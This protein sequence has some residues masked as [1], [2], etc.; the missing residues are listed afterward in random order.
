MSSLWR[1]LD[2]DDEGMILDYESNPEMSEEHA[3]KYL[4]NELRN[5]TQM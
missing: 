3:L 2:T 5:L 1:P 4:G